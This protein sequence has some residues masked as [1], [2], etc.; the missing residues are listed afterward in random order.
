[1]LQGVC[2]A[3][4]PEGGEQVGLLN[5]ISFALTVL[6]FRL[7]DLFVPPA[8]VLE[9]L[10]VKGGQIILDYGCGPGSYSAAAAR[11]VGPKGKVYA[12]DM[13]KDAVA[14]AR[15]MAERRPNLSVI[16]TDCRTRLPDDSIDAVLLFDVY[17][18]LKEPEKVLKELHRVLKDE[19][20]LFFSDHHM[21]EQKIIR[22]ITGPGS[23]KL[24][25]KDRKIYRFAK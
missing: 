12:A 19:G 10:G 1:M 15:K 2:S 23:F 18:N 6:I 20:K 14:C 4:L 17:H 5:H 13:N 11:L 22:A 25:G 24:S 8:A 9:N 3:L 7:R 16:Q 21:G